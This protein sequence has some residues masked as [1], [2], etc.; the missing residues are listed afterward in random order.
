M[1]ESPQRH[2]A[3]FTL[4]ELLVVVSIIALLI[5][6]LLPALSKAREQAKLVLCAT[7]LKQIVTAAVTYSVEYKGASPYRG[8][9]S[10]YTS[11]HYPHKML[12]QVT[13]K[14][15]SYDL[16]KE[17]FEPYLNVPIVEDSSGRHREDDDILFCP[18][19]LRQVRYPGVPNTGNYTYTHITYQYFVMARM[20][21]TYWIHQRNGTSYQPDL[22]RMSD[23]PAGLWP[24]W[25]C[26]TLST[27]PSDSVWFGH[28]APIVD[29]AP[30]GMNACFF[31]GSAGWVPISECSRYYQM[32]A[33][34][35]QWYWPTP[36]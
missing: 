10:E 14:A 36:H 23:V 11:V 3:A 7:Q 27:D 17:F 16:N 20:Q 18:G 15:K 21:P 5:A 13:E 28:D 30:T 34:S 6:I 22:S 4:I 29:T 1:N 31:D 8:G 2:P 35:Q 26:M 32:G 24:M 12:V 9:N 33:G 19:P 25:S